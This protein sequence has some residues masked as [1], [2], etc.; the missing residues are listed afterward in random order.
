[1]QVVA[2][3]GLRMWL[4]VAGKPVVEPVETEG[5][6]NEYMLSSLPKFASTGSTT[7]LL[8][9]RLVRFEVTTQFFKTMRHT[10]LR[11]SSCI[12]N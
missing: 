9:F 12:R 10:R 7:D 11:H 2:R 1:M 4:Q 6:D 5:M 3:I 8:F